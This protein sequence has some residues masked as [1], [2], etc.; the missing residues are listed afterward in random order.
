MA[1]SEIVFQPTNVLD[2]ARILRIGLHIARAGLVLCLLF[3]G[4]AKFTPEEAQGIQ[5]LVS[6]SPFMGWMYSVWSLQTVSNLI[7][8]TELLIM[9]LLVAGIWWS[10]AS[11]AGSLGAALT[12]LA[13]ISFLFS[14]PGAIV[15]GHGFPAL[16]ATGQFLIKDVVLLGASVVL[17]GEALERVRTSR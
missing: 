10:W 11:L 16:G 1:T 17:M 7:G 8:T 5:P 13:T 6:H 15:L 12:F 9:V 14:T 3:I 2:S 4:L